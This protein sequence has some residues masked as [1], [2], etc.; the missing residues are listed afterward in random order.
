[1]ELV[2]RRWTTVGRAAA[3]VAIAAV[4]FVLV[5]AVE[6]AWSS[7]PGVSQNAPALGVLPH[8]VAER[9][10]WIAVALA[11]GSAR[12]WCTAGTYSS[13]SARSAVL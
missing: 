8:D 3:D 7:A 13:S 1:M 12:R 4:G 9:L 5:H 10:V 6:A 11:V 2:G